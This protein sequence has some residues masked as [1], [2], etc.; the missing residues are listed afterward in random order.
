MTWSPRNRGEE[1]DDEDDDEVA[2]KD[3][4]SRD[5]SHQNKDDE[6]DSHE[7]LKRSLASI[8]AAADA[9]RSQRDDGTQHR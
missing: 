8:A 5:E 2:E 7:A 1:E 3:S 9:G 6:M 4:S